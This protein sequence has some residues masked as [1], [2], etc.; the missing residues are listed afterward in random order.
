MLSSISCVQVTQGTLKDTRDIEV[1][2]GTGKQLITKK[3]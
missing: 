1:F 2:L 3:L